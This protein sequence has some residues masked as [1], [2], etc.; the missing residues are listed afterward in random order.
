MR[1]GLIVAALMLVSPA[2]AFALSLSAC[3][4]KPAMPEPWLT[5][6][7]PAKARA[8]NDV[9]TAT[10]VPLAR[11]VEAALAPAAQVQYAVAPAKPPMENTYGGVFRVNIAHAA[12]V[13][14]ALSVGAWV[15]M[16]EDGKIVDS[17]DHGHGPACTGIHKI[18]WFDLKPGAHIVQIANA[19][20]PAIRI[21][22]AELS[23]QR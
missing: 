11:A 17:V 3:P 20:A 8:G 9:A 15:D 4:A 10:P 6:T 19:P 21:M 1:P 5:W 22:A 7:S 12:R 18:V 23:G 16:V 2:T 13:G 14:I